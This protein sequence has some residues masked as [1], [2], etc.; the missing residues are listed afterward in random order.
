M[1]SPGTP[2]RLAMHQLVDM[3][4]L[5]R[6]SHAEQ[7]ATKRGRKTKHSRLSI[8]K[9]KC[10]YAEC[11]ANVAGYSGPLVARPTTRCI[12]CREGR[13]S[14]YHLPCFFECHSCCGSSHS[15]TCGS[16]DPGS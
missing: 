1:Y 12:S 5:A 13:G 8:P 2:A 10:A 7:E 4:L 16:P 9:A 3:S 14:Y 15:Y 11:P 6:A